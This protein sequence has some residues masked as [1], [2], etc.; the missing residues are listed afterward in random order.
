MPIRSSIPRYAQGSL[1]GRKYPRQDVA[2]LAINACH[3]AVDCKRVSRD[4]LAK[5]AQRAQ[6]WMVWTNSVSDCAG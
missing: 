2:G 1:P 6:A 5:G 3:L 4:E